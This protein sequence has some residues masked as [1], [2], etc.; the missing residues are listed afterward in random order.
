MPPPPPAPFDGAPICPGG[1]FPAAYECCAPM[2]RTDPPRKSRSHFD[3]GECQCL[4]A[5]IYSPKVDADAGLKAFLVDCTAATLC[6]WLTLRRSWP[7]IVSLLGLCS[8]GGRHVPL[9]PCTGA[10]GRPT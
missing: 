10:S 9:I 5:A 4:L 7:I 1:P 3:N 2:R 8:S 6:P